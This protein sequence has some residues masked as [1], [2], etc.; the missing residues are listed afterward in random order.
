MAGFG[1]PSFELF[2]LP[3]EHNELRVV[4]RDLC[5]KEIAPY[6]A[7]V[8]ENSRFPRKHSRSSMRPGSRRCTSP[9]STAA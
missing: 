2:M 4:L 7:D 3:E 1:D 6:A 8:D 9:R 5:E